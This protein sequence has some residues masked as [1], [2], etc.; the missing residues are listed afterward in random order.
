MFDNLPSEHVLMFTEN[1]VTIIMSD[2]VRFVVR[3]KR[4]PKYRYQS[5]K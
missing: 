1:V 2:P 3:P 4:L 5:C